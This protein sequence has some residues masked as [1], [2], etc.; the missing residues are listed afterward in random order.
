MTNEKHPMHFTV[1]DRILFFLR[2][3]IEFEGAVQ[4]PFEITQ[5]GIAMS[6]WVQR[7]AVPRSV[8][9]LIEKGFVLEF[10]A[11]VK[12]FPR[13]RKVYSLTRDGLIESTAISERVESI[14]IPVILPN[15][16]KKELSFRMLT[17]EVN[18]LVKLKSDMFEKLKKYRENPSIKPVDIL[19]YLGKE[20]HE[21]YSLLDI[22]QTVVDEIETFTKLNTDTAASITEIGRR[23]LD[24]LK[25]RNRPNIQPPEYF[26]GRRSEIKEILGAIHDKNVNLIFIYG[27]AGIG[28]STLVSELISKY[29]KDQDVFYYRIHTWDHPLDIYTSVWEFIQENYRMDISQPKTI[30]SMRYAISSVSS[31]MATTVLVIED[32]H[33]ASEEVR[34]GIAAIMDLMCTSG[35]VTFVIT[36]RD[37]QSIFSQTDSRGKEALYIN[38]RGFSSDEVREYLARLD[39]K[40]V[41]GLDDMLHWSSGHPFLLYL[42]KKASTGKFSM[43]H[44]ERFVEEEMLSMLDDRKKHLLAY[45]SIF[46]GS[47]PSDDLDFI[48]SVKTP[49]EP[50]DSL[51]ELLKLHFPAKQFDW[52]GTDI[53]PLVDMGMVLEDG[54]LYIVNPLIRETITGRLNNY[55]KRWYHLA[56]AMKKYEIF[57]KERESLD[58]RGIM[59]H[60]KAAKMIRTMAQLYLRFE[61][62][63]RKSGDKAFFR[64]VLEYII[65][66]DNSSSILEPLERCSILL[67]VSHLHYELGNLAECES[68][69]LAS[70]SIYE[71]M[72]I[73][74]PNL[75]GRI[76][77]ELGRYYT[78]MERPD[79]AR[80]HLEKSISIFRR[81]GLFSENRIIKFRNYSALGDTYWLERDYK[82]ANEY[83]TK[84][85]SELEEAVDMPESIKEELRIAAVTSVENIDDA[86]RIF[87]GVMDRLNKV[88]ETANLGIG[89][90]IVSDY[91]LKWILSQ[92]MIT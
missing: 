78:R 13:R 19:N 54:D 47:V 6:V 79:M 25:N 83:Y 74:S 89:K 33:L 11:H 52:K 84:A 92:N 22:C 61:D 40:N 14:K 86:M 31:R 53:V 80:A 21:T 56:V 24:T 2:P 69:L 68:S 32:I 34:V 15:G 55:E 75:L 57:L 58:A 18:S 65:V 4:V 46:G 41:D 63:I 64:E 17:E 88:I 43:N 77:Y 28:K 59:E 20:N 39:L 49:K 82:A 36:S 70:L 35:N 50:L 71:T 42:L 26:I 60:L 66:Q 44:I 67:A 51:S 45:M 85:L 73:D 27:M 7:S 8:R 3:Y 1:E 16:V 9:N 90:E 76:N 5:Q 48:V 62:V 81:N 12:G 72:K 23:K 29:L 91:Y 38:L 10:K 30:T 87:D 37:R